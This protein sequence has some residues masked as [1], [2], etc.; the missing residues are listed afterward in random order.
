M[1]EFDVPGVD[2]G[3][4]VASFA[5][6]VAYLCTKD[7]LPFVRAAAYV[8]AGTAA[9]VYIGPGLAEYLCAHYD[10]GKK[11]PYAIV[12][13]TGVGGI[14]IINLLVTV[15]ESLQQRASKVVGSVIDRVFANQEGP[16]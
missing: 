8:F 6:A 4:L 5:G 2:R 14:W 15:L 11:A 7:K 12:F 10:L 9:A 13:T 1:N 3:L 16:K